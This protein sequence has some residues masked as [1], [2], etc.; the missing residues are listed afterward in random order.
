VIPDVSRPL[1]WHETS[2]T[3]KKWETWTTTCYDDH[4]GETTIPSMGC[5]QCYSPCIFC[6]FRIQASAEV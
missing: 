4:R 6:I 2:E 3:L 5:L 1:H